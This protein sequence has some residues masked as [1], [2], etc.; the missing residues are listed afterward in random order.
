MEDSVDSVVVLFLR[1]LGRVSYSFSPGENI[2]SDS[3][4]II[5]TDQINKRMI[6]S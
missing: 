6:M 1:S 2:L 4:A 3:E 5:H